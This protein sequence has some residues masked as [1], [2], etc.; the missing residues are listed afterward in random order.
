VS[1][2]QVRRCAAILAASVAFRSIQC[3]GS[4]VS[5]DTMLAAFAKNFSE[6]I[7][8]KAACSELVSMVWGKRCKP[9]RA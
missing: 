7:D 2:V 5:E 8:V 9:L 6:I 4:S 3:S 1:A